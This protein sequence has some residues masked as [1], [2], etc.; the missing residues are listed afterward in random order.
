MILIVQYLDPRSHVGIPRFL[1]IPSGQPNLYCLSIEP[2]SQHVPSKRSSL[3]YITS[4]QVNHTTAGK[5]MV[6]M[7]PKPPFSMPSPMGN[8]GIDEPGDHD[9]IHDVGIEIASFGQWSRDQ[10]GCRGSKHELK[11]PL[12]QLVRW[13]TQRGNRISVNGQGFERV[14]SEYKSCS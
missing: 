14:Q 12:G 5:I 7:N 6:A 13:K 3:L 10:S 8:H 9:A 1:T 11:E 2:R 4:S